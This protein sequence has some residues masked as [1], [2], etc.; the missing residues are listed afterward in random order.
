MENCMDSNKLQEL[1]AYLDEYAG[2]LEGMIPA[3]NEKLE[4]LLSHDVATIERSVAQQQV[5]AIQM[6][7]FE[8][9]R[10]ERQEAAG[11]SDK[12]LK[13]IAQIIRPEDEAAAEKMLACHERM[14]RAVEQIKFLNAKAMHMVETNLQIINLESSSEVQSETYTERAKKIAGTAKQSIFQTKI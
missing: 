1:I 13:E 10:E 12:A 3:Q 5:Q 2:F 6:E 14:S 7:K 11:F 4:A 9:G 8:K